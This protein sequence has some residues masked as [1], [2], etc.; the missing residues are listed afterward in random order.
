MLLIAGCGGGD[1]SKDVAEVLDKAFKSPIGSADVQLDLE[2]ELNGIEELEDPIQL[3]L[4]GPYQSGGDDEIPSV[5]WEITVSA[6]NQ[7]FTA[8]LTSTGD[9]AFIGFQ[10]TDYEV[11]RSTVA[12]LNRQIAESRKRGGTRDLAD[13]GV[14]ARDWII[15]A[16]EEGDEEVAGVDTTHVSGK[17]DVTK[18]LED[19]NKIVQEA[20]KLGGQIG[21]T[22]PPALTDEQKKQVEDVVDDPGFDAYV[23]KD[24]DTLHR[25]SADI[26]FSVPESSRDRVGG[27][28]GG[29]ISFSIE[30]ASIGGNQTVQAPENPRPVSELT[31]QL[32]GLL[33]GAL[34]G[35]TAAPGGSGDTGAE[36]APTDPEKRQA[37]QDCVETDPDDPQVKAFCEVLLQ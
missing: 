23:G 5:D 30:F 9:R 2:I 13:F 37:Y 17:L 1:D 28:E 10:G 24:D 33:G 3:T 26:E 11:S 22:A 19:L 12:A 36:P 35:A 29:R 15:D 18:V 25:L 6:Q 20:S 16:E 4:T 31:T 34:G 27:L 14:K 21:Q 32:R 7:S 8:G